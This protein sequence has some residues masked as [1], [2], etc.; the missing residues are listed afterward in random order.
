MFVADR[1]SKQPLKAVFREVFLVHVDEWLLAADVFGLTQR[2]K[3]FFIAQT[4]AARPARA[5]DR[6]REYFSGIQQHS[7]E[8]CHTFEYRLGP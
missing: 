1:L 7:F 2:S 4:V 3:N 6:V 5:I 8:H